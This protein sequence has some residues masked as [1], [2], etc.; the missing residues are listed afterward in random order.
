[1][2]LPPSETHVTSKFPV[3]DISFVTVIKTDTTLNHSQK[4][5]KIWIVLPTSCACAYCC[6][7]FAC[8]RFAFGG[9]TFARLRARLR[10]LYVRN[11]ALHCWAEVPVKTARTTL[12]IKLDRNW[13]SFQ[14]AHS[15]PPL[16]V[17]DSAIAPPARMLCHIAFRQCRCFRGRGAC[18]HYM[19]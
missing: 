15:A 3:G 12:T 2:T 4:T 1:M 18:F 9:V 10:E 17:T 16:S 6:A 5:D 7:H 8:F 19:L 13:I 14:L 11:V